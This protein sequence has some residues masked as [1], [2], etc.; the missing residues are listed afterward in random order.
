M[1]ELVARALLDRIDSE[2]LAPGQ[3]LPN[4]REAMDWLGVSR[5]SLREALRLLEAHGIISVRSGPGGGPVVR[6]ADPE[7]LASSTTL[8]LQFLRVNF[9]EVI[10]ARIAFEPQIA[11]AAA[12]QRTD[13][14]LAE[15]MHAAGE[16]SALIGHWER[17]RTPYNAFHRV[18]AESTGNRAMLVAG[19]TF[20][21][22]WDVMHADVNYADTELAATIQAHRR[23]A[24]AVL[25][26]D[27][28][29]ARHASR[30]HLVDYK[31]WL[32]HHQP[33]LLN[34]RVVWVGAP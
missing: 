34:R 7:T 21:K 22:V 13:R 14:Q 6:E 18:L 25:A 32:V 4:E 29:S 30:A 9:A 26:R 27:A 2:N 5:G 24:D 23:L 33:E 20:R 19:V 8:L 17:F 16:M 10:D 11:E 15:L 1:S 12:C 3:S 31:K 28:D